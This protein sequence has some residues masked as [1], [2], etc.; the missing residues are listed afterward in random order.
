M[1]P[2]LKSGGLVVS[3]QLFLLGFSEARSSSER[4]TAL[5]PAVTGAGQARRLREGV[6]LPFN[7]ASPE[8]SGSAQVSTVHPWNQ[9][10]GGTVAA[11]RLPLCLSVL[12]LNVRE[13]YV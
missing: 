8:S 6:S 7:D 11:P 5:K 9:A 12:L 3:P 10:C 2:L 1:L 13:L 4:M